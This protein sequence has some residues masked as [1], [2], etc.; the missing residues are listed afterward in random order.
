M[1]QLQVLIEKSKPESLI[2]K[3]SFKDDGYFNSSFFSKLTYL[4]AYRIIILSKLTQL[5]NEHLGIL[6]DQNKIEYFCEEFSHL[7][8]NKNYKNIQ[9]HALLKTLIMSNKSNLIIKII[10]QSYQY[11]K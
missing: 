1:E 8:Y 9:N 6:Q 7:W 10:H 4:W 2:K 5:K 11:M 3:Y